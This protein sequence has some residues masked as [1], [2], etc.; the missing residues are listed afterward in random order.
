MESANRTNED[1]RMLRPSLG[2]RAMTVASLCFVAHLANAQGPTACG[3]NGPVIECQATG[4]AR[5]QLRTATFIAGSEAAGETLAQAVALEV[6]TAPF[7][8]SSGGFTFSFDPETRTW[9]RTSGTFGPAFSERALTIGRGRLSAGFNFLHR[10]YDRFEDFSLDHFDVFRFQG[11]ALPVTVSDFQL[12]VKT[13]TLAAFAH[14]GLLNTVDI[15]VSIPYVQLT[16][17][18]TSRIFGAANEELQRVL[19]D[20]SGS[21]LA[22]V[23]IAGK[24]RFWQFGADPAAGAAPNG[25]LAAAVTVRVP[26]GDKDE[27]RGLGL[28]RTLVSLVGSA[29]LG[30]F[31]PHVNVG[32][33]FWSDG[34]EIPRDFQGLVTLVAKDQVQ[35]AGGVEYEVHPQLTLVA[36]VIG[37]YQRATGSVGYQS[38]TFPAN[39]SNVQ[40]AT[41]LVA[42]PDGVHSMLL[43]PGAKW[44][45]F[46]RTLVTAHVLVSITTSGLRDLVT[47][48]IGVD[49][50]F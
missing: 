15:G 3:L 9:S 4:S 29:T 10:S 38:F 14:Y 33:E 27:L 1:R 6:A 45:V 39:R 32:Y 47:P 44:N 16:L 5:D 24:Y 18:G 34:I 12:G 50:G 22:D 21:G 28:T 8:S 20:A 23:T 35:Y 40:G 31:S 17:E 26:S 25:A 30:R 19:V 7:G 42:V 11:G 36:D 43:A 2:M 46:R 41:A 37:R 49:W 13:N 48:V